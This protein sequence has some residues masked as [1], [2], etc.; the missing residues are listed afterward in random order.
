[1][2]FVSLKTLPSAL[3][4]AACFATALSIAIPLAAQPLASQTTLPQRITAPIDNSARITLPGSRPPLANP[5]ADIGPV[6][7]STRLQGISLVFGR[8]PAQQAALDALIIAQQNPASPF[9]HQWLTPDQFAAR[10]G[11][12][13]SDLAAVQ[14]W[15]QLQ[16]FSVDAVSRSRNR[17][18]FS[19]TAALVA[20]AFGAPLHYFK[21]PATA[22]L[23]AA[24]HFAPAN[25]LTVPAALASSVLAI[26]NLS[27]FRPHPH[28][29]PPPRTARPNFTSSAT[30]DHYLTPG[31]LATIYDVTPAYNA[32][33][34]GANQ[35]IAVV[36][37][38]LVSLADIAAF[39]S[40]VNITANTPQLVL[41]PNSGAPTFSGRDEGE[42]DLDLEYSST[43]AKGAQIF[44][45][46]TGSS[47]TA[48]AF[49]AINYAIDER[50]API[51]SSSYGDCEPDLSLT[52]Y[53]F[54]NT[55]LQQAAAQGQTVISASGDDG[56]T[57]C[58]GISDTTITTLAEQEQLAVD[59]PASSQ[60]VTGLG[61][62]E[63]SA[64]AVASG[65]NTYFSSQAATDTI[66][67]ALSYIPEGVWND[68]AV[69]AS[70]DP[71]SPIGAGG[72]GVSIFTPRPTWQSGVI[73]G[74]SVPTGT[75]RLVPDISLTASPVNAP[76]AYCTSDP[77]Y[78][79]Q[80]QA[81]SCT[82]GLRDASSGLLTYAG[83]TSF[84]AP[85]FA[86]MLA[87]IE[88][89]R[90]STGEGLINP[91]LYT[92][93]ATPATYATA[94]H[95]ITTGT[96]ACLS[97]ASFCSSAGES[98]YA[99]AAGYDEATG[100]GSI[101]LFNLLT[102]WPNPAV[103]ALAETTTTLATVTTFP[104]VNALDNVTIA[105]AA[106]ASSATVPT[107][108]I[109]LAIDNPTAPKTY[110]LVNGIVVVNFQ[111]TAAGQNVLTATYTGD[112]NFGPSTGT[113][114]VNVGAGTFKLTATPI[115]VVSG[116][117]ATS[118]FTATPLNGYTGD[119]ELVVNAPDAVLNTACASLTSPLPVTGTA[120][121]SE[122]FTIYTNEAVCTAGASHITPNQ[123]FIRF[124]SNHLTASTGPGPNNSS[125]N[126]T[127]PTH[128]PWQRLPLP[129]ALAGTLLLFGLDR[130]R[131]NHSNA[132]S[133]S[134]PA[135]NPARNPS[136]RNLL[137]A[138]LTLAILTTL[139]L[140]GL[141][142]TACS[143]SAS[144]T[145]AAI[146]GNYTP[147]GT[148]TLSVT[149]SD[150]NNPAQSSTA[151]FTLTVQ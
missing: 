37:Q 62:T 147:A 12:A 28:L 21:S 85:S 83:G 56:S 27:D 47:S 69:F 19:G 29:K 25:D 149:G 16:G 39:Q 58:Y 88:Q 30:G 87:L 41:V 120:A 6:P 125:L 148:Y 121:V 38:S 72:G 26:T 63:F 78:W 132:T 33:F 67:S 64:A 137:R 139:S 79:A 112:A 77:T 13:D 143:T 103:A 1:M 145:T 65:N 113:L 128:S 80:G 55:F 89:S 42:S 129:A 84:D 141:T 135:T 110:P 8:S 93:A 133:Q 23:P 73:G 76:L 75:F 11:V 118:T 123:R 51:I 5:A 46:Y 40:A 126:A 81:S 134:G 3:A 35:S 17:I 116:S 144:G 44:F 57:D 59:F 104:A 136:R 66:S 15:L 7:P 97:G 86:A 48:G 142:L 90:N 109:S 111:A 117:S 108:S 140:G 94:F 18:V 122:T 91:T 31:D 130:R 107:G 34:T 138:G 20:S 100:L 102:A 71:S 151:T 124:H 4:A 127:N 10:F 114:V 14:S 60:Y 61:G 50:I 9:Y 146:P 36:G 74:T 101:D 32:G 24:T 2:I 54:N 115:T 96:N 22:T 70:Q 131:A 43:I 106:I 82:S 99:A 105:V 45:V 92:L 150:S 52:Q 68:D 49:D 119:I 95:D 53:T 98:G